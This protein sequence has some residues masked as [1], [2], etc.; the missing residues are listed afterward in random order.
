[1]LARMAAVRGNLR[2]RHLVDHPSQ[3]E[4][5]LALLVAALFVV[6][7]VVAAAV[8]PDGSYS[9]LFRAGAAIV[10]WWAAIIAIVL[11]LWPRAPV[12]KPALLA[13]MC[14]TGLAALTVLSLAWASDDG[15]AFSEIVRVLSY[16]GLFAA[17][18]LASRPGRARFWLVGLALGLGVVAIFALGSRLEPSIFPDDEVGTRISNTRALLSYPLG[19]WVGTGVCMSLALTLFAWLSSAGVTRWGRALATAALP[20]PVLALFLTSSQV[21]VV[22]LAAGLLVLLAMGPRRAQLM[23]GLALGSAGAA[24]L[25]LKAVTGPELLNADMLS[26]AAAKRQGHELAGLTVLVSAGV[27]AV[28]FALDAWA[29]SFQV[30]LKPARNARRAGLA[31]AALT[32]VTATYA[33]SPLERLRSFTAPPPPGAD[34]A[35]VTSSFANVS[36]SGRYQFWEAAIDGL[37]SEPLTGLGAGQYESWWAQHGTLAVFI[38]DAHSWFLETLAELGLPGLA[39]I[40]GFVAVVLLAARRARKDGSDDPALPAAVAVFVAGLMAASIDWMW[41]LPAAFAPVVLAAALLTGPALGPRLRRAPSRFGLGV[42]VLLIG[43][44][45]ILASA[46][47]LVMEAKLNDSRDAFDRGDLRAAIEDAEEASSV[48]PWAAAP[49]LQRARLLEQAGDLAGAERAAMEAVERAPNDL[50]AWEDVARIQRARGDVIGYFSAVGHQRSLR[51]DL[52][53]IGFEAVD[54]S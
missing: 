24:L 7:A 36:S 40:V 15:R 48:Q 42:G 49:Y 5:V 8:I 32:L 39:L 23:V 3:A 43:W 14:L 9:A 41:E 10:L 1:M 31:L 6:V 11:G 30:A 17:I 47:T 18:V 12:P 51:P 13:G 52:R 29:E 34:N 54:D 19:Y 44:L 38:R 33:L 22:T 53:V 27:G 50:V 2:A 45:A 20:A 25:L 46:A 28:R 4:H 35:T 26:T 21:A 16:L 37:R